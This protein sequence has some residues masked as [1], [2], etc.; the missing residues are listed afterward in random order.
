MRYMES[1]KDIGIYDSVALPG[2]ALE[3]GHYL[4]KT[5]RSSE[6]ACGSGTA[7]TTRFEIPHL[8]S[9]SSCFSSHDKSVQAYAERTSKLSER[10]RQKFTSPDKKRRF[11]C[12][13]DIVSEATMSHLYCSSHTS[14]GLDVPLLSVQKREGQQHRAHSDLVPLSWCNEP[15]MCK[16]KWSSRQ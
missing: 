7:V 15:P 5:Y 8:Y 6:N 2:R 1:D 4:F 3:Q 9:K 16:T 11:H 12:A 14:C 10:S 13:L